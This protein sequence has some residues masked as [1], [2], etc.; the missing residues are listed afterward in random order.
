MLG[1]LAIARGRDMIVAIATSGNGTTGDA[2]GAGASASR[3]ASTMARKAR[4]T[5]VDRRPL[6][7]ARA[8]REQPAAERD[9]PWP[10]AAT[11]VLTE[12]ELN[13]A[14]LARQILLERGRASIP[15]VLERM[16]TLQA[17]YAPSIYIGLWT[18]SQAF[19]REQLERALE[20][21]Q[22][23]QGT[24]MRQ[25]STWSPRRTTG[26][27]RSPSEGPVA[28]RGSMPPIRRDYSASQMSAA[29][30]K[31]KARLGDGTMSRKEIHELLGSTVWSPTG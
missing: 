17:Q 29:A 4:L 9:S 12:Q 23:A 28:K 7:P 18:Q 14:L 21:R 1:L 26:R 10:G 6:R 3:R 15:K 30:R 13:R 24:L 5:S 20:R 25:R 31:L 22:V 16:G 27:S 19:E 2:P 8:G 11:R